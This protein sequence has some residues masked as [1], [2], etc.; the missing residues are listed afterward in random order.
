LTLFNQ[1]DACE[2]IL[3]PHNGCLT[4][5]SLRPYWGRKIKE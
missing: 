4:M 3:L 5:Q 2:L 1:K